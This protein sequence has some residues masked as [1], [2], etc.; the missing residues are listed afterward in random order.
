MMLHDKWNSSGKS[1]IA[2]AKFGSSTSITEC[3]K[4]KTKTVPAVAS[5]KLVHVTVGDLQPLN[6]M[7]NKPNVLLAS[8]V[9]EAVPDVHSILAPDSDCSQIAVPI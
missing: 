6:S 4:P 9:P 5:P 1:S 7:W 8:V 3:H 2:A